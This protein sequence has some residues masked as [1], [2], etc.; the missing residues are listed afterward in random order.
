MGRI[1]AS[2][3]WQ[4]HGYPDALS[5]VGGRQLPCVSG[6]AHWGGGLW[7]SALDH[8]RVGLLFLRRGRWG[9]ERVLSRRWVEQSWAPCDAR[10]D[11]GLLWWRN[12]FGTVFPQAPR[13]GRCARGNLGR[14]L[15]W[16]DPARDL[17][18]VSRWSDDVGDLLA[19]LSSAIPALP[20]A[21]APE[22]S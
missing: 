12:D 6:G 1:G 7:A 21:D 8:A 2:T 5:V 13:T 17:V 10:P 9:N 19:S 3:T 22:G 11:Y 20:E 18:V 14:Q 4:W 16:V 15:V